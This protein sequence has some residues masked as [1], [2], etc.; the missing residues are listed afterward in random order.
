MKNVFKSSAKSVS[1]PLGLTAAASTT[2]SATQKK[3]FEPGMNPGML[4][5]RSSD[6]TQRLSKRLVY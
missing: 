1:I 3:I 6:L 5:L 4:I 2:D